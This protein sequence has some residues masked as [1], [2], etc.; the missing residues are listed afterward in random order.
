MHR[1]K[2]KLLLRQ[3]YSSALEARRCFKPAIE[4]AQDFCS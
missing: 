1:L 4:I 2:D 3:T